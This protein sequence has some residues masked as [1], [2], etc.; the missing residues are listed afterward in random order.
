MTVISLD[1]DSPQLDSPV[2]IKARVEAARVLD[3]PKRALATGA[4]SRTAGR[5]EKKVLSMRTLAAT[6]HVPTMEVQ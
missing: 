6:E 3:P 2:M 5:L 1:P 4:Q